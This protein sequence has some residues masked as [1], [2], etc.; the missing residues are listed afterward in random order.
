MLFKPCAM[1]NVDAGCYGIR[2][3]CAD[4][5]GGQWIS[6]R[7]LT[8]VFEVSW[9]EVVRDALSLSH[10]TSFKGNGSGPWSAAGRGNGRWLWS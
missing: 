7:T 5:V 10:C 1:Q 9:G 3:A 4:G 6:S 2:L 8:N